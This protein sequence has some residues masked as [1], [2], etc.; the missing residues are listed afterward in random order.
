M[1]LGALDKNSAVSLV[2]KI[3]V[4]EIV[5][6]YKN[7]FGI[8]IKRHFR[9][10]VFVE[11]FR[12]EE[13]DYMFY[14]PRGID[15]DSLFYEEL[16]K[17]DWYYMRWKWEHENCLKYLRKGNKLLEIGSAQGAFMEKLSSMGFLCKGL[18][19]NLQAVDHCQKKGL[20]VIGESIQE[21]AKNNISTYD[22]VCSFQVME[23]I[24]NIREV[25]EASLRVLRTG[26]ILVISVPNNDSFIKYSRNYLNMPPHHIGLWNKKSLLFLSEIFPIDVIGCDYEPLQDYHK[27]YFYNAMRAHF[28]ERKTLIGRIILNL[29][30]ITFPYNLWLF[31]KE[32]KAFTIQVI[33]R[34]KQSYEK[35]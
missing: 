14:S 8:D 32:K 24:D 6:A 3:P 1:L 21:H 25:L 27:Q 35:A 31:S 23:H 13:S 33:Y 7:Q 18:E 28:A 29:F 5:L 17:F 16:Q 26:G 11:L 4:E 20:Q 12:E 10:L 9:D 19:L 15:G 34:K 2:E 30:V 22:F